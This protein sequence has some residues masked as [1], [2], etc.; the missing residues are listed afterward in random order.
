MNYKQ[1]KDPAA[2]REI[3][4]LQA[5]HEDNLAKIDYICMEAGVEIPE[6]EDENG[7]IEELQ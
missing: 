5:A 4:R 7:S 2:L 6:E 1:V 3:E